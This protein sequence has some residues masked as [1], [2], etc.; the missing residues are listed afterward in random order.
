VTVILVIEDQTKIRDNIL[1]TLQME[2]F[3]THGA[4]NG[5]TGVQL[6][7]AHRPDVIICDIMMPGMDGYTVLMELQNDPATATIPFIF[8]T[9]RA[10]RESQRQ[11][12]ELGADDYLTKPFTRAEILAAVT[13]RL[14]KQAAMERK[15]G[16]DSNP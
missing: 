1:E 2:G 3:G 6:A 10:D 9:A 7:R 4:H 15:Y 16:A 14:Q 8:L 11:G 5:M 13:T 12:M